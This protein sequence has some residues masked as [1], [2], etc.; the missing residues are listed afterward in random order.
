MNNRTYLLPGFRDWTFKTS[1]AS[2]GLYPPTSDPAFSV[3]ADTPVLEISSYVENILWLKFRM[4][5]DA[6]KTAAKAIYS[7][8]WQAMVREAGTDVQ[9]Q[10]PSLPGWTLTISDL[11]SGLSHI[12]GIGIQLTADTPMQEIADCVRHAMQHGATPEETE[13]AVH[14]V[15]RID[16]RSLILNAWAPRRKTPCIS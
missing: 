6:A 8:D 5:G 11:G 16:F 1:D 15:M 7:F 14:E 2:C 4:Q 13:A 3:T 9:H 12:S 10:S